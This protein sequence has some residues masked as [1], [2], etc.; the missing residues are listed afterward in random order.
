MAF[1]Q[2]QLDALDNA[3]AMGVLSVMYGNKTVQYRSVDDMIKTRNLMYN[4]LNPSAKNTNNRRK[5]GEFNK[6]L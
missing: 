4:S 1:T 3:I 6:G 2:T 5:Y